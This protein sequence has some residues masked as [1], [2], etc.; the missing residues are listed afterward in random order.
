MKKSSTRLN[1]ERLEAREVLSVAYTPAQIRHAYGFDQF[2]LDGS[3]QT[4]AI[5]D[6]YDHP[7][8]A[9]NLHTFDLQFGLPDPGFAKVNQYGGNTMPPVNSGWAGEIAL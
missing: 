6:A 3:G 1:V 2:N 7:S 9:S 4:I 8:I 5:V